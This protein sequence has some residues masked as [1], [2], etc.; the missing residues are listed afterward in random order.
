MVFGRVKDLHLDPLHLDP[1]WI[2]CL[3]QRGLHVV[4]NLLPLRQDLGKTF[5]TQN[6]PE[7]NFLFKYTL[8][9]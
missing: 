2:G 4:G 7:S 8:E 9:T 3:V 5:R 6:I 1:P